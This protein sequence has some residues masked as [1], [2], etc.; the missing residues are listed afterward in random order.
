MLVFAGPVHD[1][2]APHPDVV[3]AGI[4]D[5][6]T[7]W[8]AL[9]GTSALVSPS[10]YESFSLVLLEGWLAGR[11]ALVNAACA[12]TR[13]HCRASGG[14]LWFSS[15]ATF[16]SALDRVLGDAGLAAHLGAQGQA[17]VDRRYRWPKL[18][19]RYQRFLA[20][21]AARASGQNEPL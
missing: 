19:A 14:G 8:G 13:D 10:W 12:A 2:P 20:R 7:K 9:R 11:P 1:R 15:Y 18:T 16:E 21:V 3:V 4:V 5:E 6:E 17:Y